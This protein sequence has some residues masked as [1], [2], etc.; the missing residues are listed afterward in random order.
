MV[1]VHAVTPLTAQVTLAVINPDG[2]E[3]D[4]H[5]SYFRSSDGKVRED[6][7]AGSV[8]ADFQAGTI[9][10]LNPATN[11]A[12]VKNTPGPKG[13]YV[14]RDPLT[15]TPTVTSLGETTVEGHPV[16]MKLITI[17]SSGQSAEIWTATDVRLTVL[18]KTTSATGRVTSKKYQ[19]IQLVEP[20]ASLFTIPSS[21]TV[22]T[23]V[24]V[25]ASPNLP[26]PE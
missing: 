15:V 6:T 19:N 10:T 13:R 12:L 5:G 1:S 4:V 25:A 9:T 11:Q 14:K 21:Y 16:V 23:A 17:G 7:Q 22:V 24:P 20:D 26:Q 3:Q 18:V 8:I 2:T